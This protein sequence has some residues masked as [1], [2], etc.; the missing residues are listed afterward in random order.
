MY[1]VIIRQRDGREIL[2]WSGENRECAVAA[3]AAAAETLSV[4][5]KLEM[6]V[7]IQTKQEWTDVDA[8]KV[9]W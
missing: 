3:Q 9:E 1:R 4:A 2:V 7:V 6:S 8:K 5:R